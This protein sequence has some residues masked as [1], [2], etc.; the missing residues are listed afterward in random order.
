LAGLHLSEGER[1]F[2]RDARPAGVILFARNIDTPE[3]VRRLV[4]DARDAVGEDILVLIDQEGGRVRRLRPPQWRDLPEAAR[5]F[6]LAGS[7]AAPARRAA[8]LVAQLTA[9]ELRALG[10]NCN[11]APVLDLPVPGS[12]EIIGSR[13]YG[14]DVAGVVAL[15]REVLD[16]Y[17]AGGILPVIKH[18]PGHGRA[19]ADSHLAL[20]TVTASRAMLEATDFA[21]FKALAQAPAA[22][23]AHVVYADIDP[24]EPASTSAKVHTD[25]IRGHIGFDGLLMSDDLTM[26]ALA[27]RTLRQRAEAVLAAGSDLALHCW[28]EL[29]GMAEIAAGSRPLEG[30]ARERFYAALTVTATV[31][32]FDV[33]AAEACLAEVLAVGTA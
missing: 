25:I 33:A 7:N 24:A 28:G 17:L 30:R 26:K 27:P 6:K 1:R 13:A 32:P 22:M 9:A 31:A 8:N 12:H 4:S 29:E 18:I 3:Q 15:A 21:P 14:D 20:P 10:I 2:L 23:S 11:C 19:T 16:G 5:Y